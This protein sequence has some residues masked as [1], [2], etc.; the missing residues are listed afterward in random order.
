MGASCPALWHM[1]FPIAGQSCV[2]HSTLEDW[3]LH[4]GWFCL[5][6]AEQTG[7]SGTGSEEDKRQLM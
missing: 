4:C 1:L 2:A 3:A 5:W 7:G 6:D